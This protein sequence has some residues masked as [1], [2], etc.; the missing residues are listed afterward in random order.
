MWSGTA[1]LCTHSSSASGSSRHAQSFVIARTVAGVEELP[2]LRLNRMR[3]SLKPTIASSASIS[4]YW[5]VS[6]SSVENNLQYTAVLLGRWR[7][8]MMPRFSADRNWSMPLVL[9]A[10]PRGMTWFGISSIRIS[11]GLRF[12]SFGFAKAT[13][14]PHSTSPSFVDGV[15]LTCNFFRTELPLVSDRTGGDNLFAASPTVRLPQRRL[16]DD[17]DGLGPVDLR[18]VW[19]G[20]QMSS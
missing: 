2:M 5:I 18:K 8:T 14:L 16:A 11:L 7:L 6:P 3:C 17:M 10:M 9:A 12:S 1:N 19:E 20:V 13:E 4:W 15:R